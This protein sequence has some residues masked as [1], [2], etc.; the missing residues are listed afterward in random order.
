MLWE[1]TFAEFNNTCFEF[2]SIVEINDKNLELEF[3]Y[4]IKRGECQ[5]LTQ[6]EFILNQQ[7]FR[8]DMPVNLHAPKIFDPSNNYRNHVKINKCHPNVS[9]IVEDLD[10]RSAALSPP[11]VY[12]TSGPNRVDFQ[13]ENQQTDDFEH[14]LM[15]FIG[16]LD[17]FDMESDSVLYLEDKPISKFDGKQSKYIVDWTEVNCKIKPKSPVKGKAV[18][19]R[20]IPACPKDTIERAIKAALRQLNHILDLKIIQLSLADEADGINV[21]I[22]STTDSLTEQ[23]KLEINEAINI[24]RLLALCIG[25]DE[26]AAEVYERTHYSK[27]ASVH[28]DNVAESGK[29]NLQDDSAAQVMLLVN[30]TITTSEMANTWTGTYIYPGVYVTVFIASLIFIFI[31]GQRDPAEHYTSCKMIS[32]WF[33]FFNAVM[34]LIEACLSFSGKLLVLIQTG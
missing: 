4:F 14:G 9:I 2:V 11:S 23:Q 34:N 1:K 5:H 17:G 30:D 18:F 16:E 20:V 6:V 26:Q 7:H 12:L 27:R 15:L 32:H 10:G 29:A 31:K 28:I 8:L 33:M 24:G 19:H 25:E 22:T 3:Y 21:V 13:S